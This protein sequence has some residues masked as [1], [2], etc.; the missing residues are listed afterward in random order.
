MKNKQNCA[1]KRGSKK[2]SYLQLPNFFKR[3][4]EGRK[5]RK[6][7]GGGGNTK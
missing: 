1:A 7:R 3:Q 4:I 6:I 2:Y 5:R